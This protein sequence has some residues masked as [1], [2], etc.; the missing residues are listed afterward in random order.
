MDITENNDDLVRQLIIPINLLS[1]HK[2]ESYDLYKYEFNSSL[3]DL[4]YNSYHILKLNL[5]VI[6]H[7]QNHLSMTQPAIYCTLTRKYGRICKFF[8][9]FTSTF[10]QID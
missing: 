1:I 2:Q 4:N 3:L 6:D 10:I 5:A 7:N 9:L 8:F